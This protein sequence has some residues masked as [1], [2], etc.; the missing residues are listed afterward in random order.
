MRPEGLPAP[1]RGAALEI[2]VTSVAGARAAL[3]AGAD[4]VELCSALEL[5][6]VSP[7]AGLVRAVLEATAGRLP[8][9]ALIRPRP[10]DFHYDPDELHTGVR[11]VQ[12]MLAEGVDGVVIG[13]LGRD[14]RIATDHTRTLTDAARTADPAATVTFH[15][16]VDHCADAVA[17]MATLRRL[18]IDRVLTSGQAR[19][20]IDGAAI[21]RR[22]VDAADGRLEVMAG[23]GVDVGDIVALVNDVGVDAVHLSAKTAGPSAAGGSVSLGAAD[24]DNPNAYFVTDP[25]V[26]ARAAEAVEAARAA[27]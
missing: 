9:H 10:G 26:V 13:A 16:A 14:R 3:A 24:G 20:A 19:R 23:G 18:G 11:E 1:A 2:A 15:R 4:R 25:A 27:G 21:L 12:A 22:M 7:S 6:G 5:G 17:E 8:V